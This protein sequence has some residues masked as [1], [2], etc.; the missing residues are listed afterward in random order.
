MAP[1]SSAAAGL[2][3]EGSFA[4]G[5]DSQIYSEI[6]QNV[7]NRTSL[8]AASRIKKELTDLL[9][10]SSLCREKLFMAANEATASFR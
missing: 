9:S 1:D 10:N 3:S 7:F 5:V 8:R 4:E 2:G 6:P